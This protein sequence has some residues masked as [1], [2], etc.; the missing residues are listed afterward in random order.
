MNSFK[1]KNAVI[2]GGS[3]GLGRALA[4]Q[5]LEKGAKVA[6]VARN[7]QPLKA[8]QQEYP[9][10]LTFQADV[11]DKHAIHPLAAAI[12]SQLGDVDLLINAASSLGPTPLRYLVDTECEDLEAVLQTN[13]I[14][15]F[16]LTK[17]L[18]PGM[19]LKQAE[20]AKL[21]V[22][23]S[24]DAAISAYPSWGSYSVSK[25]ALDHLSRIF[26]AE[27]QAQGV[28]FLAIDP[29][30]M[31]TPMHRAA[32]PDANSADLRDPADSARAL[33]ALIE[34]QDFAS[35]ADAVRRSL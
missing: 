13:L 28:R 35:N 9:A 23:I 1:N 24:S 25:A 16:R 10:L 33:L 32:V 34:A 26:D 17:A 2:T 30:D 15:P 18:L 12:Q 19:L 4:L 5:L 8:L 20:Q 31:D 14:G 3:S 21:V 7:P 22:N 6:I 27:L 29:G 11:G